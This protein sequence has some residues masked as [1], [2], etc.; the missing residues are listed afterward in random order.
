[1]HR[2]GTRIR[3]GLAVLVA[4]CAISQAQSGSTE[5][6]PAAQFGAQQGVM[7]AA[8][9]PDGKH[10]VIIGPG[11]GTVNGVFII[12]VAAGSF[13]PIARADG[14]PMRLTSCNWS[15]P[16]RLVCAENGLV[17]DGIKVVP[18]SRMF[19]MDL[20]GKNILP[21]GTRDS[22]NQLYARQTDGQIVDWLDGADGKIMM[23]RY[24]VPERTTGSLTARTDEGFGVDII[25]THTQK[26]MS[27]EKPQSNVRYI[28]DGRGVV[29]IMTR[30]QVDS[31]KLLTGKLVHYYR[32]PGQREW[33]ELASGDSEGGGVH[34]LAVDSGANAAYVVQKLDGR[35]ALYRISL[36]G[37]RRQ[38]LVFAHPQV[39][40]GGVVTIGRRGRVIGVSYTTDKPHVEY[41]DP[42]YKRLAAALARAIPDLPLISFISASAD[43]QALLVVAGSDNKPGELYL[44][45]RSTMRLSP[46]LP[47]RRELEK[48]PLA[49]VKALSY[50]AGDGTPVPAYLTLPPGI[51]EP[52]GLP[53]IVM[54]HGGPGSRDVW[55]F[56]WLAQ[57]YANRGFAVLQPNFRG[58]AGFG[59]DWFLS[60]GFQ[61]WRIAIGD[62]VDAGRWLIAQGIADPSKLAIFGWS[63]G[64]Y[65]ALQ[66][67]VVDADLFKAVV[68]VAP[69]TDLGLLHEE[70]LGFTT[71][72]LV[73]R[74]IGSGPH[75]EEGSPARHA[76]VFKAPVLMFHGDIDANVYIEESRAMDRALK[77]AGKSSDLVVYPKLDHQLND[78]AA[79]AD[80]LRKSYAFLQANLKL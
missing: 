22:S 79:R 17:R 60:N 70:A 67:N 8:L 13:T 50:A 43:E 52:R 44:L 58:S 4:H 36:D 72:A 27:V 12:D 24:Y 33:R 30:M 21:L 28:S 2:S 54:P 63:Y 38:E 49:Q 25:D 59:D 51:G 5:A 11:P 39:D 76:N 53:A 7:G 77:R 3:L 32:L 40:V 20:D 10:V 61:S 31:Q 71:S 45:S 65:A 64:G 75:I 23:S 62:V 47:L 34:P 56:N 37:E 78:S 55:G 41:F 48:T 18:Y 68:A 66:A 26:S 15:S 42:D 69:V 80:L 29:R 35:R 9:A 74:F 1:M 73:N 16:D 46:L 6:D 14:Q 57:Y 19:A